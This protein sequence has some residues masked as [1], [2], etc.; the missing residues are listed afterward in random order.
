MIVGSRAF[1]ENI[2]GFTP[3]DTDVLIL[4]DEPVSK[5]EITY[6]YTSG[7][8]TILHKPINVILDN[9]T[10]H[11]DQNH[12]IVLPNI[13]QLSNNISM[14]IYKF[15][16]GECYNETILYAYDPGEIPNNSGLLPEQPSMPSM[17]NETFIRLDYDAENGRYFVTKQRDGY[18]LYTNNV[19]DWSY[20]YVHNITP[21]FG[22]FRRRWMVRKV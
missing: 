11:D 4:V 2:D 10:G 9:V 17:G 7:P 6:N 15:V 8:K 22:T 12:I 20:C 13:N 14:D 1:F 3:K 5:M 19:D 21:V 16:G 18:T